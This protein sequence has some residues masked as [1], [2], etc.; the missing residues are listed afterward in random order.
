MTRKERPRTGKLILE[1]GIRPHLS[2]DTR[3]GYTATD[4][5][6]KVFALSHGLQKQL[7]KNG[8]RRAPLRASASHCAIWPETLG[9]GQLTHL[10]AKLSRTYEN[11]PPTDSRKCLL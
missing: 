2:N 1:G 7:A 9:L 6:G 8:P 3:D 5:S 11:H 4:P 10:I